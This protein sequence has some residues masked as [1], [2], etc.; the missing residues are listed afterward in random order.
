MS[1]FHKKLKLT[2]YKKV[3]FWTLLVRAFDDESANWS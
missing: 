2:K 3:G 1:E